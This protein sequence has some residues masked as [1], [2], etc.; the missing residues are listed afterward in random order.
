VLRERVIAAKIWTTNCAMVHGTSGSPLG[1]F[2]HGTFQATAIAFAMSKTQSTTYEPRTPNMAVDLSQIFFNSPI[3]SGTIAEDLR[4]YGK[5]NP[6]NLG[7]SRLLIEPTAAPASQAA[8]LP[9]ESQ[10]VG[11]PPTPQPI[12][13]P[14]DPRPIA[15]PPDPRPIALPADPTVTLP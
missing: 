14:P 12:G 7:T 13:L 11:L 6:A 15:L 8:G 4:V 9:T 3:V 2:L 10:L 5:P 1:F